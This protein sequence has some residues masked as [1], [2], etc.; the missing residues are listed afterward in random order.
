[1]TPVDP[2]ET[3][4]FESISALPVQSRFTLY[5]PVSPVEK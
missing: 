3:G 1:M 4:T 5:A 2:E